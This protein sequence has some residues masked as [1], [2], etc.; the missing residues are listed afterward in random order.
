MRIL[1]TGLAL[2]LGFVLG[3]WLFH[4]PTSRAAGGG[5]VYITAVPIIDKTVRASVPDSDNVVGFS[6]VTSGGRSDQCYVLTR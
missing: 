5:S 1:K 6:C 4:T 3:A 2:V